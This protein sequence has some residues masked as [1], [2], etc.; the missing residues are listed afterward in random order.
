MSRQSDQS[1]ATNGRIRLLRFANCILPIDYYGDLTEQ[2]LSQD[3]RRISS[4]RREQLISDCKH[5]PGP[6]RWC[7]LCPAQWRC[8]HATVPRMRARL[9]EP[10]GG[11]RSAV[12]APRP[13]CRPIIHGRFLP[14]ANFLTQNCARLRNATPMPLLQV[15][16]KNQAAQHREK[17]RKNSLGRRSRFQGR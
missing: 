12:C 16:C 8:R 1:Q 9:G 11:P 3:F 7:R 17:L 13:C 15:A 10:E 5:Q 14:S 6:C 2:I 4:R